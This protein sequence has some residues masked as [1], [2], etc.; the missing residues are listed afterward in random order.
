[1]HGG[2]VILL[3]SHEEGL[4]VLV[5]A[6]LPFI[7]VNL[8]RTTRHLLAS[9]DKTVGGSCCGSNFGIRGMC[10]RKDTAS[11]TPDENTPVTLV[12]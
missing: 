8:E 10:N 6:G 11:R 5:L 7:L 9:S 1:M 2:R 12:L 3:E 4:V